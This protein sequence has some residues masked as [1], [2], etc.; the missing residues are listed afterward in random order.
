MSLFRRY[1]GIEIFPDQFRRA[2][3]QD[4]PDN[5]AYIGKPSPGV[6]GKYDVTDA[7]DQRAVFFFGFSD[8]IICFSLFGHIRENAHK[9]AWSA[10]M[11]R[12]S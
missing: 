10:R 5:R 11:V 12:D 3:P 7:L 9:S 6:G 4:L 2:V 8:K 1:Q